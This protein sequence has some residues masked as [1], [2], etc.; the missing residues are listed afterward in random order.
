MKIFVPQGVP[1][2]AGRS[3]GPHSWACSGGV[4]E[5]T[6]GTPSA[7]RL[8]LS[9]EQRLR[10]AAALGSRDTSRALG[11]GG[12]AGAR[13]VTRTRRDV[14]TQGCAQTDLGSWGGPRSIFTRIN[15]SNSWY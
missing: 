1:D 5:L 8:D 7:Q 12:G 15:I 13:D 2:E 4:S 6:H 9:D 11:P 14:H 3:Y 10:P